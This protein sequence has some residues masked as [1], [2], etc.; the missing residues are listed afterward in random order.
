MF[1]LTRRVSFT[2]SHR[3]WRSDWSGLRNEQ[4][5][6][7]ASATHSHD[8]SCDVTV[9]GPLDEETGMVVDLGHLDKVLDREVRVRFHGMDITTQVPEFADGKLIPTSENL[10]RF[11]YLKVSGALTGSALV[12]SVV[13]REDATIASEFTVD[14]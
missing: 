4:R 5:F 12:T 13:V 2:A 8:Y 14:G 11:I 1:A 7:A 6:G 3:Y 10:A 9:S